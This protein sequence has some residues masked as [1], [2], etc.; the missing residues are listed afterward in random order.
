VSDYETTER[1]R[2]IIVGIFVVGAI[3]ALLW[4]IFQFR[5]MPGAVTRLSSFP[6]YVQ[7]PTAPGVQRDTPVQ[8][9]GYQIGRVTKVM[10]PTILPDLDSGLEYHQ[11][12]VVLSIDKKYINI[13]S[14]V[15]VKLMTRGL[16]SSFIELKIDPAK[17]PSREDQD[18]PN[19]FLAAGTLLQGS[20]GMTSEFF[21]EE[22][23]KKLEML[24][25]KISALA[26]NLND[27]VGDPNAKSD[28]KAILANMT[29]ASKKAT[30][31]F[32]EFRKF[33]VTGTTI[34][35]NF[36]DDANKFVTAV[37]AT[38]EELGKTLAEMRVT[39]EKI[40]SGQGTAGKFV[41]DGQLYESLVETSE[42]MRKVLEQIKT[43]MTKANEKGSLPVKAKL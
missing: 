12:K 17:L 38:S 25:D 40:N 37:V 41:N 28:F 18:D 34:L 15:D 7:F 30:D 33:S 11:T 21:P 16:G 9:C 10:A 8:F 27:V 19:L 2:N 29:D 14:N 13:P 32:E 36:E 3:C 1:R 43:F 39:L 35:K 23:Q 5:D 31:M 42:E 6:V 26:Q 22:S 4:L 20:T 24:V